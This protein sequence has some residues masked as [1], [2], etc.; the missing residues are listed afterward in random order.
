[1][2]VLTKGD[3]LDCTALAQCILAVQLDLAPFV[4]PKRSQSFPRSADARSMPSVTEGRAVGVEANEH[5]DGDS[6]YQDDVASTATQPGLRRELTREAEDRSGDQV[7]ENKGEDRVASDLSESDTDEDSEESEGE[8]GHSHSDSESDSE[9]DGEEESGDEEG[10]DLSPA[11]SEMMRMA[12][13]DPDEYYVPERVDVPYKH[14]VSVSVI[15]SSTG[16]GIPDLWKRLCGIVK[17]DSVVSTSLADASHIVREHRLANSLRR[18]HVT[19]RASP[20]ARA[21]RERN[22]DDLRP[23]DAHK[24]PI[25]VCRNRRRVRDR[26]K[27]PIRVVE[28]PLTGFTER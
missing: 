6:D 20:Q 23:R 22:P 27:E 10:E 7:D 9:S 24:R 19:Q 25:L 4:Q 17:E 13:E 3:L 26:M 12:A 18:K 14:L 21:G 8:E 11:Q 5:S 15:S 28:T 2:I 16:A 1:M